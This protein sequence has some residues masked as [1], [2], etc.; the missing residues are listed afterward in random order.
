MF[1]I[2]VS[3]VGCYIRPTMGESMVRKIKTGKGC[4]TGHFCRGSVVQV[5][6][7]LLWVIKTY[8]DLEI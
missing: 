2:L 4:G 3:D 5:C 6:Y 1:T 8:G 7:Y